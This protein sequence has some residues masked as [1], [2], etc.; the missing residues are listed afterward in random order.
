MNITNNTPWNTEDLTKFITETFSGLAITDVH[1]DLMAPRSN[2]WRKHEWIATGSVKD[3]TLSLELLSPKRAA[4]RSETLD[5][6]SLAGDL[7]KNET[8]L[9]VS[10]ISMIRHGVEKWHEATKETKEMKGGDR[11]PLVGFHEHLGK[12]GNPWGWGWQRVWSCLGGYCSCDYPEAVDA[13]VIRG[14]TAVKTHGPATVTVEDLEEKIRH[15][16]KQQAKYTSEAVG[17]RGQADRCEAKAASYQPKIDRL[18][19]RLLKLRA[20]ESMSVPLGSHSGK[21]DDN[22]DEGEQEA[23]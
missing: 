6:L 4:A 18:E 9:P 10:V 17:L 13:P 16:Q 7:Q 1:I 12:G 21:E 22:G 23:E 3:S 11:F 5:R 14:D 8:R 20:A 2:R 15:N 19:E